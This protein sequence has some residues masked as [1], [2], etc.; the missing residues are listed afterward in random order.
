MTAEPQRIDLIEKVFIIRFLHS[1][2]LNHKLFARSI[3]LN[4]CLHP[5]CLRDGKSI[6]LM[7]FDLV[8]DVVLTVKIHAK[9]NTILANASDSN[10]TVPADD[11][12]KVKD[13][14]LVGRACSRVLVGEVP[15]GDAEFDVPPLGE[16]VGLPISHHHCA[17]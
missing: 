6:T 15:L 11:A 10:L 8:N 16:G 7:G 14:M 12:E 2:S 17:I 9:P 3:H 5:V 1:V 4:L 13:S